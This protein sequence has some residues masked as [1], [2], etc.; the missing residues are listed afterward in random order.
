MGDDQ[1]DAERARRLLDAYPE[2]VFPPPPQDW[3]PGMVT[4]QVPDSTDEDGYEDVWITAD[5]FAAHALRT[6]ALP[7]IADLLAV[8]PVSERPDQRLLAR[9][10]PNDGPFA[11]DENF[12]WKLIGPNGG[13]IGGPYSDHYMREVGYDIEVL[14]DA[15]EA[16]LSDTQTDPNS[17]A[18]RHQAHYRN[19]GCLGD[20][21]ECCDATCPCHDDAQTVPERQWQ[22][23][24]WA[25]PP[26]Y[27]ALDHERCP[28][29]R[30][31]TQRGNHN[32]GVPYCPDPWHSRGPEPS[33]PS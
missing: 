1:T 29:C 9:I 13:Q 30:F 11:D 8:V 16:V 5:R 22:P 7:V 31:S 10:V 18:A 4:G 26:E 32:T 20:S 24:G 25:V 19:C 12:P 27:P 23:H 33:T 17:I 28:E 21:S 3:T 15:V 2:D 14:R 6:V